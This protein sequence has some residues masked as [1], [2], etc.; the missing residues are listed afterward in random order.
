MSEKPATPC[1][2]TAFDSTGNVS[3][4]P[5]RI[6]KKPGDPWEAALFYVDDK[7][8]NLPNRQKQLM[9]LLICYQGDPVGLTVF[10][11]EIRFDRQYSINNRPLSQEER[12]LNN[13]RVHFSLLKAALRKGTGTEVYGS[14]IRT[15]NP[16]HTRNETGPYIPNSHGGYKLTMPSAPTIS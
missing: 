2:K 13:L 12:Y 11:K 14:I 7:F 5:F 4:G 16:S 9:S 3:W 6:E 1:L 8:I 10:Q 15:V